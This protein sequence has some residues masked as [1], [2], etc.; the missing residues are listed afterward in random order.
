[1]HIEKQRQIRSLLREE[2]SPFAEELGLY[3][4]GFEFAQG[5]QGLTMRIYLDGENGVSIAQC[6]KLTKDFSSSLKLPFGA[7]NF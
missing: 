2:L 1:M 4:S 3:I 6:A 5:A 7:L